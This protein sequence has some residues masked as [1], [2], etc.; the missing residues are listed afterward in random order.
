MYLLKCIDISYT[1]TAQLSTP[2]N[3][4]GLIVCVFLY[5]YVLL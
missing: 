2:L 5:I 1:I 4:V 3:I